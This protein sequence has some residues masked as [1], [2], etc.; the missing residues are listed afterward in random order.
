MK[1]KSIT[2]KE[3]IESAD[4]DNSEVSQVRVR[5]VDSVHPMQCRCTLHRTIKF[6]KAYSQ[7]EENKERERLDWYRP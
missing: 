2:N 4:D 7:P 5:H 6:D 3:I 1:T